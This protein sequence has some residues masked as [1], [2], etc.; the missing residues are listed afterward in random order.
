MEK[1]RHGLFTQPEGED[2]HIGR[3][4]VFLACLFCAVMAGIIVIQNI[5]HIAAGGPK[6]LALTLALTLAAAGALYITNRVMRRE[7]TILFLALG[8]CL[9]A[10]LAYMLAVRTPPRSDFQLMYDAALRA[11][12]GDFSWTGPEGSY[13]W[14][15]GYQ[16]PFV[17]Y[18]ALVLRLCPSLWALKAMNLVFMT[19]ID[20]LIYQLG[21]R[22]LSERAA[23]LSALLYAVYPASIHMAAVL[24]NQHISTFFLL[25]GVWI[26]FRHSGLGGMALSGVC[27]AAGNLMRPEGV[28][29]LA[30]LLCCGA[31][32]LVRFPRREVL[33][34]LAAGVLALLAGFAALSQAAALLLHASGAAPYGIGNRAPEWKFVVGLEATGNGGYSEKHIAVLDIADDGQRKQAAR[35]IIAEEFRACDNIPGFF[36]RKLELMWASDEFFS[37]STGFLDPG[38]RKFPGVTVGQLITCMELA[39]KAIYLLVWLAL[40][41]AAV[42]IYRRREEDAAFFC[43]VAVCGA[44]CIYLLIEAQP[45]YRYFMMPLLFALSGLPVQ[46]LMDRRK[47][48]PF[49]KKKNR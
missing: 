48:L 7:R 37:W 45:R 8:V 9:L 1:T 14:R 38:E 10:R 28:V 35:D 42:Q 29:F 36:L 31:S 32:L 34:R 40:P 17:L 11:A 20:W 26:L 46:R 21:R 12:S 47:T 33:L 2:T 24:T 15:W 27:L 23:A 44:V 22:F 5:N 6:R 16:I 30:T 43:L 39:E 41:V 13:F 4:L 18:Q 25:L 3:A 49:R 19:G